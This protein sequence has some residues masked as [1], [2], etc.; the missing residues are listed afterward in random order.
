MTGDVVLVTATVAEADDLRH[1]HDPDAGER[2]GA[3]RRATTPRTTTSPSGSSRRSA[4]A[5]GAASATSAAAARG[6]TARRRGRGPARRGPRAGPQLRRPARALVRLRDRRRSRPR[7]ARAASTATA[8][9]SWA[10]RARDTSTRSSRTPSAG[11]PPAACG[12]TAAARATYTIGALEAP[13]QAAY[14]VRIPTTMTD[15]TYWIEWR[16]RAG[17]DAGEPAAVS[18]GGLVRFAPSAVGG[19][20]LLDMKPATTTFDDAE[21]DVGATFTDPELSLTITTL[22]KTATSLTVQV[23]YGAPP[24]ATSFHTLTPCRVFDT[25]N[26]NGPVRR[27][28][29]PRGLLAHVRHQRPVRRAR[30]GKVDRRQFHG[31]RA[32]RGRLAARRAGGNG[33]DGHDHGEL[34]GRPDAREQRRRRHSARTATSSWTASPA[35]RSTRSSTSSA[36]SSDPGRL[37]SAGR[38]A[39]GRPKRGFVRLH[40]GR[41]VARRVRGRHEH[42]FELRRG[43]EDAAPRGA[44]GTTSGTPRGRTSSRRRSSGPDPS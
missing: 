2:A 24:P 19:T 34:L 42:R 6:S 26:A 7:A 44:R 41:D 36:G 23:D 5:A 39:E 22:S 17:F 16:N 29:D 27:T 18:N 11:C 28:R 9:T 12:C 33:P 32:D 30:H 40:G 35:A 37:R 10:T 8:S 15:R 21:L 3:G 13:G 43:D 20:D 1:G 38:R 25:R 31:H 4:P 14:A